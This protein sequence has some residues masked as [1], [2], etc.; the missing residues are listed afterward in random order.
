[1]VEFL[2]DMPAAMAE[3]D[4]VVCRSGAGAVAE[5]AAAGKPSIL[6]PF[7]FAADNHQLRNAEAMVRHG[8]S[9]LVLDKAMNGRRLFEEV[10]QLAMRPGLLGRMG[11]AARSLA[12]PGAAA[13][14]AEVLESLA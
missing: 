4:L 7:P 3:A 2:D 12:R 5:L 10:S 11:D 1:V 14:A 8:A 13:R 6:V 9:L